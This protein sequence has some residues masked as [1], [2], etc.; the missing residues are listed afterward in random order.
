MAMHT[1]VHLNPADVLAVVTA[2]ETCK[3]EIERS[4]DSDP[5]AAA[6]DLEHV[7]SLIRK[8]SR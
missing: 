6:R 3:K 2:L 8:I 4:A 7:N 5:D 1:T